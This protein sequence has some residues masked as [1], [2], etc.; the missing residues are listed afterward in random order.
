MHIFEHHFGN[1]QIFFVCWLTL[2][3]IVLCGCAIHYHDASTGTDHL[4]GL[5][6][7]SMK[8]QTTPEGTTAVVKGV[9]TLGVAAG[10][11]HDES[12]FQT[13]WS[14][15]QRIELL[16]PDALIRL[17]GPHADFME[18]RIGTAPTYQPPTKQGDTP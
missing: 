1:A 17:D 16:R 12:Y 2:A 15:H 4:W 8:A 6:H 13:G 18:L 11:S 9:E 14:R 5:G 7:L 3:S 10:L